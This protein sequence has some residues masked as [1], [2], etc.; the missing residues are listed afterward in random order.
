[1]GAFWGGGVKTTVPDVVEELLARW[2][3]IEMGAISA[4]SDSGVA[5]AAWPRFGMASVTEVRVFGDD[6]ALFG[7]GISCVAGRG[8]FGRGSI[9]LSVELLDASAPEAAI[10]SKSDFLEGRSLC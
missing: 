9:E 7:F 3:D 10:R 2:S 5:G 6:K 8:S 4:G 1:M